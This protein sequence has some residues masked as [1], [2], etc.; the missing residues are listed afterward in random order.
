[1]RLK[2]SG[3]VAN[4]V[5]PDQILRSVA[6][7]LGLHWLLRRSVQIFRVNMVAEKNEIYYVPSL[8]MSFLWIKKSLNIKLRRATLN[9]IFGH[10]RTAKAQISLR[11]RAVWSGPSLSGN[12]IT[13]YYEMDGVQRP[14]WH[15]SHAQVR[16]KSACFITK[17]CLYNVDPLKPL[18]FI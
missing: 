14:G 5:D 17:I 3:W 12:R 6:S 16:L 2:P 13:G 1:M 10:M 11:F 15:S 7:D 4:S 8:T 18:T 9:R